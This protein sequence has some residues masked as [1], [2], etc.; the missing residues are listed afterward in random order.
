MALGHTIDDIK[1]DI[2]GLSFT[3]P[4]RNAAYS[5]LE[6]LKSRGKIVIAGGPH[7]THMSEECIEKG[8]DF[9][10]KG[11]GEEGL[12]QLLE[13]LKSGK[14]T[15]KIIQVKNYIPFD[16]LPIADRSFLPIKDYHYAID[17]KPATV[18][19]TSRGCPYHCSFCARID[20]YYDFK[21][22]EQVADEML[23]LEETY[24]FKAFMIFDDIFI[25]PKSRL[26]R[27]VELVKDRNYTIRCFVRS[28]LVDWKTCQLLVD[29]GVYEVGIGIESG[30]I[31]ILDKN[32]KGTSAVMNSEAIRA[33]RSYGIRAKAFMIVGLPGETH[34][35]I[36][37]T[38]TWLE[39]TRPDDV[40][41]SIFQPL[42]GSN[43]FKHP[44]DYDVEFF[45]NS[46]NWYKGKPGEYST[47]VRTLELSS[48]EIVQYRDALEK[49]FKKDFI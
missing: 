26:K 13:N 11:Y 3:T 7:P 20:V 42:P 49:Q 22:A 21:T 47:S 25:I 6:T 40:D 46:N 28:N 2:V 16:Q 48:E 8:F 43:I 39:Q 41:L 27:L 38:K 31:S 10:V 1:Y 32:M 37:E 35:T 18:L 15:K 24:G 5:M 44:G 29:L 33:L 19:M 17:G 36:K 14:P 45:Y 4:Q 34:N 12:F 23:Y 30:S 9:V